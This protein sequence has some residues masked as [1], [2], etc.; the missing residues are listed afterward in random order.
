MNS[1]A[2]SDFPVDI[3][4]LW[5]NSNDS[6]WI[7]KKNN[8]LKKYN[9]PLDND[10]TSDCR[11]TN[12]DELKFS[13]RSLEK[14]A[15]WVNQIFIVTDNQIPDWLDIT[16]P[17][18]KIIDHKDILPPECLPTFNSCAIET[19]LHKIPGLSEHF[20]FANDDMLFGQ[21][22]TKDFFFDENGCPVFRFSKRRI[23]NKP[24]RHLYGYTISLA[25]RLVKTKYGNYRGY[26]PHHNIDAY[27]KSDMEKC[28]ETFRTG[29]EI[30]AKQKF[31]EKGCIQRSIFGYYSVMNKTAKYKI[32]DSLS[33]KLKNLI[34]NT[35]QDSM[36]LK[37]T[38][39]K[40]EKF[41]KKMP[42][43]FCINDSLS[44]TDKDRLALHN[45]FE[46][47]F[48][49]PSSFEKQD[50]KKTEVYICY[51]K[52]NPEYLNNNA[53]KAIEAGA[54]LNDEISGILKDNTGDNISAKNPYYCELTALYHLWKNSDAEYAGLM[55][56]RRLFDLA[57]GKKRWYNGFPE[58]IL[59]ILSLDAYRINSMLEEFDIVLPMK[60]VIQQSKTAYLYY[61]K[62]HYISDMD[63]C[64]ELIKEKYPQMYNTAVE[65]LKNSNELYLYNMFIAQK[66]F[67][68]EY[69]AWLFDILSTL[70]KEIQPDV[71]KRDDFQ[72]RVYGFLAERLFTIYIEYK[73]TK[74]L[75]YIELPVVYCETNKKRYNIFQ[76]R[77][78]IYSVLVKFGI[79][80]PHWK[81]QYGV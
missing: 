55:H 41:N 33:A 63:R 15:P 6:A 26:F 17:K 36:M 28:C 70:E 74:G 81:E 80:R 54:E 73:K 57:G 52:K 20:L 59:K 9:K 3:V 44:T 2:K 43:L 21:P 8:E 31:R 79:R 47:K 14:F 49:E 76:L 60:R 12:I 11:F 75:K 32:V 23:I 16:N 48:P 34:N 39:S 19:A 22:V 69:C 29:F 42:Y 45:F 46:L 35:P 1:T 61:K 50:L 77:R 72:K 13:L 37:L 24:Y 62:R 30:T 27:R 68:N 53:V 7:E 67:L 71:E 25:Y 18:I 51:N 66:E 58:D 5:C 38:K 65:T 40:L 4:Y 56:Y 64:F 10:A 78:K